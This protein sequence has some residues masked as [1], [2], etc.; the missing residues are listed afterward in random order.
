MAI[1]IKTHFNMIRSLSFGLLLALVA[2]PGRALQAAAPQ[3]AHEE[4][5]RR[6]SAILETRFAL[7]R[8]KSVALQGDSAK[9][10]KS[11]DSSRAR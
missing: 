9:T 4:A 1:R 5:V 8:A 7:E 3:S 2:L 6:Q 10:A 11:G